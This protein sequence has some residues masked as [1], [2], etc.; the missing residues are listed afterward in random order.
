MSFL[1]LFKRKKTPERRRSRGSRRS[2]QAASRDRLTTGWKTS[3]GSADYEIIKALSILRSR[4]RDLAMN[5]DY[6]KRFLSM[7]KANVVGPNGVVLQNKAKNDDGTLDKAANSTIETAFKEWGKKGVCTVDGKFS[8]IDVQRLVMESVARDGEILIRKALQFIEADHLDDRLDKV[9]PNGNQ[10]RGGVEFDKWRRPVAYYVYRVHPG[11]HFSG[12]FSKGQKTDRIPADQIIHIFISERVNQ[13]RGVPWLIT[14]ATRLNMLGGYEEAE[15]VAA[16][17]AS[18]KMGFFTQETADGYEGDEPAEDDDEDFYMDAEPGVMTKLGQG[19]GFVPWDP[20]HPTTAFKDFEKAILRGIA[21]GLNVSY[22]SL[23]NDLEGVNYSSIRQGVLEER[24]VWMTLQNW[25]IDSFVADVWGTWLEM[26]LTL[27]VIN[28]PSF[29][30]DKFNSPTWRPKRW[31]WVDP[32]KDI[33]SAILSVK[34]GVNSPQ[35]IAAEQGRDFAEVLEE[36]KAAQDMAAQ[37][38]VELTAFKEKTPAAP[39][40][41]IPKNE[42]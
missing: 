26:S 27:G 1:D 5:N 30:I 19:E 13:T 10:I 37:N 41:E 35:Q 18:A 38:G 31:S 36:I 24:A 7:V 22:V 40:K 23:A 15:L 3:I 25:F 16:R 4:S 11:D 20:T 21:S 33:E 17:A 12:Y 2:Y 34:A 42:G 14:P 8:W 9:L 39:G 29:K 6:A 28:L 32:K